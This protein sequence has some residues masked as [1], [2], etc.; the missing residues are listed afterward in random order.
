[1]KISAELFLLDNALMNLCIF[2]LASA[3]T[4]IP[5]R[6]W[7]LLLFSFG[8]ALYAFCALFYIPLLRS[9][10]VRI[11]SFLLLGLPMREKGTSF[12]QTVAAVLFSAAAIG[13]TVVIITLVTGGSIRSEGAIVG[14]VRLRAAL[15]GLAA[16]LL[17]PRFVRSLLRQKNVQGQFTEI[18]ICIGE[19]TYTLRALID[20][21]N[22]LVEP[23]SGLPVLLVKDLDVPPERMLLYQTH[24]GE[25]ILF[26]GKPD[27]VI[28]SEYG[29]VSVDCY[30]ARSVQPIPDADAILPAS[31]IP[32]E[33]R[34]T[35]ETVLQKTLDANPAA[36]PDRTQ[37]RVLVYSHGRKPARTARPRRG[38]ALH[39][40]FAYRKMG[41]G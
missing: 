29:S 24:D 15:L 17:L 27:A 38:S 36:V 8:G 11:A 3:L 37:K 13:G 40:S 6:I 23:I 9:T 22:L 2:L 18:Q 16:A 32:T 5:T 4:G 20:T 19:Q 35:N 7:P 14:T 21:G 25:G 31:L 34:K 28:L 12:L 10:P 30:A 39:R 1:M 26:A 33:W 41:E